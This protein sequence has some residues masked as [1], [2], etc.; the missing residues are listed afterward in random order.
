MLL[1]RNQSPS[2]PAIVKVD[3]YQPFSV[4]LEDPIQHF[5][6]QDILLLRQ[7]LHFEEPRNAWLRG[8]LWHLHFALRSDLLDVEQVLPPVGGGLLG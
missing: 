1:Q 2:Q 4:E 7:G 8:V 6:Y 5:P 3:W